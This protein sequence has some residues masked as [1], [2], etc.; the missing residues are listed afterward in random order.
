MTFDRVLCGI[1]GSNASL[2]AALAAARLTSGSL[3]L[4]AVI[5]SWDVLLAG[6]AGEGPSPHDRAVAALERAVAVVG[7]RCPT[8][9]Q[10]VQGSPRHLLLQEAV[11]QDATLVAVG[12]HGLGHLAR[13]L[14][15]SVATALM[16]DAPCSVLVARH[17][18]ADPA[19]P[20][21]IV[22]G[23]DGSP[24]SALAFGVGTEL[25]RACGSPLHVVVAEDG[26]DLRAV[27]T[28]VGN[29]RREVVPG[30]A[31]LPLAD[32]AADSDLIVVGSRGLRG[33]RA[34]GSVSERV[35]H[36]ASCS[37]L[38]VR[39]APSGVTVFGAGDATVSELMSSPAVV[40]NEDAAIGDLAALMVRH[41]IS[42]VPIVDVSGRLVGLVS[43]SAF[44]GRQVAL[45]RRGDEGMTSLLG[46]WLVTP[47]LESIF[48][49]ARNLRARDV[50]SHPVQTATVDEPLSEVIQH[51]VRLGNNRLPVVSGDGV[52]VGM[53]TRHDFVKMAD[54]WLN[55]PTPG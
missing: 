10:L 16:R 39:P 40:A 43:Q 4:L 49:R 48:R 15:G 9:T 50:M 26:A 37:V 24:E 20:K 23:V 1:D 41:R 34:I 42:G 13:W 33:A 7:D 14:M 38:V 27:R 44:V 32:A 47:D 36:M 30:S 28:V 29:E 17:G 18:G 2:D 22:V 8:R 53:L 55:D 46:E 52:P 3:T 12:T 35:V 54:R 21:S 51:M 6:P 31:V 11:R 19:F 45:G 25:H 5:D